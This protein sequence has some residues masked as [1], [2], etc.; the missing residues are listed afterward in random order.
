MLC[1]K[2]IF[3]I[4]TSEFYPKKGF[5][6]ILLLLLIAVFNDASAQ[7]IGWNTN[8]VANGSYGPSPWTPAT[9]NAQ[10]LTSGLIRG[11]SI[12]Y[13]PSITPADL[14]WG[15][16]GGWSTT[17]SDANSFYFTFQ[18]RPGYKVNLTTISS[19]TRRSATGPSGVKVYYSVDGSAFVEV[20][21]WSTSSTSGTTGTANS[22][23]LSGIT[24][25]QNVAAGKVIKF[26]LIPQGSTGNY[27]ITGGTNSLKINGT[28]VPATVVTSVMSG[29]APICAG[30]SA[31]LQVAINGGRSPYQLV[32]TNGV[33]PVTINNYTSGTNIPVS[34]IGTT[35]Y[36]VVSVT[37]ADGIVSTSNTGSAVITV[38][39]LPTV[40]A[41]NVTTC[42]TGGVTL[43]GGSPAGGT[44]SIPN[45]YF[46]PTTTFTYSYT[47]AN[48]CSKTSSTYTFTRN[49][50]ITIT[51]QPSTASQ[52]T[53]INAP[54][55]PVSVTVSGS[56]PI[57]Y[58][59]Y[60]NLTASTSGG[61]PAE[62]ARGARTATYTPASDVEGTYY[63][64]VRIT[65]S[66]GTVQSTATTGAFTVESQT[67]TGAV[68]NNQIICAG[69]IPEDFTVSGFSGNVVR[70]QLATNE[71]FTTGVQDISIANAVLPGTTVG[72]ITQTSY[73]RALVQNGSC[74]L[75][76]TLPVEITIK[77]T[78]WNGSW[79]NGQPDAFTSVLFASDFNSTTNLEACSVVVN[80][81]NVVFKANHT[82][83][84]QNALKVNGGSIVFKNNASLVQVND[85][86]NTGNISYER[87]SNLMV[88]YDYTYWSSPVDFQ[89][90]ANFSP[91]TRFDKYFWWSAITNEWMQV[92][93]PALTPM[94]IGTG[95]IIRAPYTFNAVPKRFEGVFTGTPNNGTY[96]VSI[97]IYDAENNSNLI[98]NPYPS[99]ISA[100]LFLSDPDNTAA[101]GTGSSLYFWTHNTPI[102]N[103]IYTANDYAVYN[104]TGSI[105]TAPSSGPNNNRPNGFI[106]A[107]Q[108]F[109]IS[110]LNNGTAYFKNSMRIGANNS[111]F[112][113]TAIPVPGL[114]RSRMW[115]ELKNQ[116]GAFKELLIG[117][118]SD[119][120]N[121]IDRGFD[122]DFY[123][124]DN[125]V[126]FYSLAQQKK[127]AIQGR[128]LPFSVTDEVPIGFNVPAA[129]SYEI[130]ISD[131]DGLF[132]DQ[133]I[134]LEDKLLGLIHDLKQSSYSFESVSGNF[135]SRFVIRYT[136]TLL[137]T[138][139]QSVNQNQISIYKNN[140]QVIINAG[141]SQ[142]LTAGVFDLNGRL[143]HQKQ[144][145]NAKETLFY[146]NDL[147]AILLVRVTLKNGQTL[148]QKL[149]N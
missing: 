84:I 57:S 21:N 131:F 141:S 121:A 149:Q 78:I 115:L 102:G 74:A 133:S 90:L 104:Y 64:Y 101:I 4:M 9:L 5:T 6:A 36:N 105:G 38:N 40:T 94:N 17:Q 27:Y 109:M 41:T 23:T 65:N 15:G 130:A 79:S 120:T 24:A 19:A 37:D 85:A 31:N 127:L 7:I 87:D 34:P 13:D 103:H 82:L 12:T 147:P 107:G 48:N 51:S 123:E 128:A 35:T 146:T 122:A 67:I 10:L 50:P 28:V 135:N 99:A 1:F 71:D 52:M 55:D 76:P 124:S 126:G 29:T 106:A 134:Y 139:E 108:A 116:S 49:T 59:W 60:Q 63:Y 80:S 18:A 32:Y 16:S 89:I 25:L 72:N 110:G 61:T 148:T 30:E 62:T 70:W 129:G 46:G 97:N 114:E 14:C 22:T 138:A 56:G 113:K 66:C 26:R 45:P 11:T 86:V 93:T 143:L 92:A 81:G 69:S 75:S 137:D 118:V 88:V 47:N 8:T 2:N 77:S 100:D 95:Y 68:S 53:C 119:A 73:I 136:D 3:T 20:A 33:T 132:A 58:Q 98:G 43:T 145:V 42:A 111:Q 44:Y 142:I 91:D 83:T 54:F 117:Y 140:N 96:P 112:F 144:N 125:T 39:P